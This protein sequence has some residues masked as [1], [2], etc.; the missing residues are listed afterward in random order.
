[1]SI[2]QAQVRD[3]VETILART[4]EDLVGIQYHHAGAECIVWKV[5]SNKSIYA[6]RVPA[7][8]KFPAN[9]WIEARV[10]ERLSAEGGMVA[11]PIALSDPAETLC[12]YLDQWIEGAHPKRGLLT[13]QTCQSL[14]ETLRLLHD[15]HVT[16]FGRPARWSEELIE[17]DI[18]DPITA[19]EMRFDHPLPVSEDDWKNHPAAGMEKSLTSLLRPVLDQVMDQV[20]Q[21]RAALCHA[22]LHEEQFI[23]REGDLQALIDLGEMTVLDPAWDLGSFCYFHGIPALEKLLEGYSGPGERAA[24]FR[25]GI[26]FSCAIAMHHMFRAQMPGKEHRLAFANSHLENV[27]AFNG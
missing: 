4:G 6:F 10:R 11:K 1:M 27:L 5:Q 17:G 13:S 21:A 19:M 7:N 3:L 14:G 8:D 9:Y 18:S 2:S 15:L 12:W 16:G 22:D 25:M 24:D 26:N 20:T 23:C